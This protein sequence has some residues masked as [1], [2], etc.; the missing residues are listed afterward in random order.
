MHA[1]ICSVCMCMHACISMHACICSVCMCMHACMHML[2][3]HVYAH[4]CLPQAPGCLYEYVYTH[5]SFCVSVCRPMYTSY[6]PRVHAYIHACLSLRMSSIL[7][8]HVCTWG[9]HGV[10]VC[11]KIW[12]YTVHKCTHIHEHQQKSKLDMMPCNKSQL[13]HTNVLDSH[14]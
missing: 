11:M 9:M 12:R 1:C 6:T 7:D 4:V 5:K 10:C 3:L 14:T 2:G 13:T 8:L